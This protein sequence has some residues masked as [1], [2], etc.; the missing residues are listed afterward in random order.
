[1]RILNRWKVTKN[2]YGTYSAY[3]LTDAWWRAFRWDFVGAALSVEGAED[4]A[5]SVIKSS[6]PFRERLVSFGKYK[7]GDNA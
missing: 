5:K 4:I 7:E 2:R 1:M 3:V 6:M